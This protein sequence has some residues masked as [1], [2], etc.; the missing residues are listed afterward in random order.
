MASLW[1][2]KK[3]GLGLFQKPL[4]S[5]QSFY[6]LFHSFALHFWVRDL[7]KP[8]SETKNGARFRRVREAIHNHQRAR[9][10]DEAERTRSSEGQ[11]FRRK[12][13]RSHPQN[14]A[15]SQRHG[16]DAPEPRR[17]RHHQYVSF[18]FAFFFFFLWNELSLWFF[19]FDFGKLGLFFLKFWLEI[20]FFGW[21]VWICV[22]CLVVSSSK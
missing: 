17:R 20:S 10:E 14:L 9:A 2:D 1:S 8:W 5:S 6:A 15:W 13:H 22:L 4:D 7:V 12:S 19:V 11:H 16:Q 21:S 18:F 3:R